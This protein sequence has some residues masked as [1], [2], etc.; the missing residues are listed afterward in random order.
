L[1]KAGKKPRLSPEQLEE[2]K[3][4]II[5]QPDITLLELIEEMRLPVCESALCKIVN[6]KLGL[7]RKKNGSRG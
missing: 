3:Q 6:K 1:G 2:V 7:R 5:K 4:R